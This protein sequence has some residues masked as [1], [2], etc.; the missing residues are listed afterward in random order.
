[1]QGIFSMR[2]PRLLIV[3]LCLLAF[4]QA[5]PTPGQEQPPGQ[6]QAMAAD[7]FSIGER[8]TYVAKWDPPWYLF[9]LPSMEAG[10]IELQLA[11][12]TEYEG[13][14]AWKIALKA[15]SS[16]TLVKMAGVKIDDEFIFI[17]E[18]ETFCLLHVSKRIREGKRKRQIDV[19]YLRDAGQL[20][21]REM[22]ESVVPA[23]LKKDEIKGNIPPCLHDPFSATYL[24][25]RSEL[26][27]QHEQTFNISHDDRIKAIRTRVEKR[28]TI[29]T[30]MG[31]FPAWNIGTAALMGGLF[32]EGGQ[33]R[34][35]LSADQ[36]RIP[37]QFEVKVNL[38]K[39]VGK[40]TRIIHEGS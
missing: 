31:N 5:G 30:P 11:G 38:G 35:W 36:R 8:L 20:H 15:H 23:K 18:P 40:L 28:E 2:A 32:K 24:L 27:L 17:V 22:D 14:K 4:V 1:M 39:V 34:L 16:G 7:P 13:R 29:E 3:I 37:L 6:I 25:R 26:S 9:F 10:E 33:F 19:E 21:I 12:E